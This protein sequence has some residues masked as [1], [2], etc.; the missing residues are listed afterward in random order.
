VARTWLTAFLANRIVFNSEDVRRGYEAVYGFPA[1]RGMTIPNAVLAPAA[2]HDACAGAPGRPVT[3][4]FAGRLG[5]DKRLDILLQAVARM[6]HRDAVRVAF[7]GQGAERPALAALSAE[8]GI[9]DRVEWR[10]LSQDP[11]SLDAD[12]DVVVLCSPRESSSNMILEAMAAGKA[13]VVSR[14]GGMPE[15]VSHGECGICVP[16]L[17]PALLAMV[18]DKLAASPNLRRRLGE[19]ARDKAVREHDPRLIAARWMALL[20]SVAGVGRARPSVLRPSHEHSMDP[21]GR[22]RPVLP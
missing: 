16:P 7:R 17:D 22:L 8:L 14:T 13:V 9:A 5:A 10:G 19:R 18:L 15:L 11:G 12:M 1:D 2:P 4:G 20:G 6:E 21:A 3:L